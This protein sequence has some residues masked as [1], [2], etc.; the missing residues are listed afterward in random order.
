MEDIVWPEVQAVF[1]HTVKKLHLNRS[2]QNSV[3]DSSYIKFFM[4][5]MLEACIESANQP[6]FPVGQIRTTEDR[7]RWIKLNYLGEKLSWKS[8]D[9]PGKNR[10]SDQDVKTWTVEHDSDAPVSPSDARTAINSPPTI[11][12]RIPILVRSPS[13]SEWCR[14][15][16]NAG[17]I[18]W[19]CK[20]AEDGRVVLRWSD[21][22]T[23]EV[24]DTIPD[25]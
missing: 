11:V 7:E 10:L 3:V 14:Y 20:N 23:W 1:E 24:L 19:V 13:G 21:V 9:N 15:V 25:N 5:D 12:T 17:N 16:D 2:F 22:S 8:I 4:N 6:P 18:Y